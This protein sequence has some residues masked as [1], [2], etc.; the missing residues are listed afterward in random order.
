MKKYAV[1]LTILSLLL[2]AC[3]NTKE[4]PYQTEVH[5]QGVYDINKVAPGVSPTHANFN[6]LLWLP[7]G[8]GE[9][10]EKEWPMIVFLHGSGD[11]DNDSAFVIGQGLPEVLW[12]DEQPEDFPFIVISPQALPGNTWWSGDMPVLT[13]A[14]I[15]DVVET[16]QVDANRIYLTGLSMGGYGSWI[17]AT[18]YPEKFAAVASVSGS[19]YRIPNPNLETLCTL[20]DVPIWAIH[21]AGDRISAPSASQFYVDSLKE[22]CDG[23]VT[24]TLYPD[25]GHIST[26]KRAYRNPALYEWFLEHS[27][28]R[29][30]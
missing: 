11:N 28:D 13:N 24:W 22:A 10:P 7:E 5:L 6:Y 19:G 15:D 30:G 27:L 25:T 18:A 2:I 1:F 29:D 4:S 14:L 26:F 12:L 21:G 3:S 20:K 8:Y 23:D 17:Q 16:Y 9:D